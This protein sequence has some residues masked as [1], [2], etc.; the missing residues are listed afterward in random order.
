MYIQCERK[1]S[2][3]RKRVFVQSVKLVSSSGGGRGLSEAEAGDGRVA[4]E[5]MMECIQ[6]C[7]HTHMHTGSLVENK[8]P[9]RRGRSWGTEGGDPA[10]RS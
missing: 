5:A 10:S 2:I 4:R 8:D 3:A 9:C 6:L 1:F 7:I